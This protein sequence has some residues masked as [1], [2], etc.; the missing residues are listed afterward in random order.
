MWNTIGL[1][2]QGRGHR[3]KDIPCQDAIF[4]IKKD[5]IS[6]IALADGA[7]SA[8]HSHYGAQATVEMISYYIEREF[9]NIY[10]S[11]DVQS[12]QNA[13][14]VELNY[15][16]K[17]LEDLYQQ[18]PKAFSS[19]CL[20][21]AVKGER[22]IILHLGDGEIGAL[23]NNN[24][25]INISSGLSGEYINSTV[26]TTTCNA[27]QYI[28]LIKSRQSSKFQAFFLLSDG[29]AESLYAKKTQTFSPIFRQL[30]WQLQYYDNNSLQKQLEKDFEHTVVTRTKDDCSFVMMAKPQ[31][32]KLTNVELNHLYYHLPKVKGMSFRK[33]NILYLLLQDDELTF[34][35]IEKK[36]HQKSKIL[37][38]I[39]KIMEQ[40]QLVVIENNKYRGCR[41]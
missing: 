31:S 35:Q 5:N 22:T 25:I 20:V 21:V 14:E 28:R 26:F 36:T 8:T 40:H 29:S 13:I 41:E 11:E 27:S 17:E 7:G 4:T 16:L 18:K 39:L 19:T 32:K 10:E 24:E 9:D 2:I 33:V 30:A 12:I 38:S 1:A 23:K 37:R 3:E 6:I 34:S 15:M